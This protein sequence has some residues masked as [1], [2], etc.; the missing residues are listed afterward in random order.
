MVE[1][2]DEFQV[3]EIGGDF[4]EKHLYFN[5][6]EIFA[7]N[8][9][10]WRLVEFGNPNEH[11]ASG[12]FQQTIHFVK[13][14]GERWVVGTRDQVFYVDEPNALLFQSTNEAIRSVAF[15]NSTYAVVTRSNVHSML[16]DGGE[17]I[18]VSVPA[19]KQ[20]STLGIDQYL[21]LAEDTVDFVLPF[22]RDARGLFWDCRVVCQP[23]TVSLASST[24]GQW[25]ALFGIVKDEKLDRLFCIMLK[26]S[27]VVSWAQANVVA[28]GDI[29][30][31]PNPKVFCCDCGSLA[32][33]VFFPG[34]QFNF[35][36]KSC[37]VTRSIDGWGSFKASHG[38]RILREE[39]GTLEVWEHTPCDGQ[40]SDAAVLSKSTFEHPLMTVTDWSNVDGLT[41]EDWCDVED[42]IV[43]A[44]RAITKEMEKSQ[45]SPQDALD[46]LMR[47]RN[48]HRK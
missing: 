46:R 20:V 11:L 33:I 13:P 41:F 23:T 7:W 19:I 1:I 30:T 48:W 17:P 43:I 5:K 42:P 35:T 28:E 3:A 8:D 32:S 18:A 47:L 4:E 16:L 22:S 24:N 25:T 40:S 44:R 10:S 39:R 29:A 31:F 45:I 14:H 9:R 15:S 12:Q 38:N 21:V 36:E 2:R 34:T 6:S 27:L 37:S 26:G